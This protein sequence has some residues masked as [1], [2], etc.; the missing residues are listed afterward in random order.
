MNLPRIKGRDACSLLIGILWLLPSLSQAQP[1]DWTFTVAGDMRRYVDYQGIH[2]WDQ[3]CA[4]IAAIGPGAFMASPGDLDQQYTS[5]PGDYVYQIVEQ[6]IAPGYPFF[7]GVGNHEFDDPAS[8]AWIR[9]FDH[10]GP[11]YNVNPGPPGSETTTYSWNHGDAHFVMINECFDGI[12]DIGSIEGN[13]NPALNAWLEADLAANLH[14][15]TFVF[16]HFPAYPQPDRDTGLQLHAT[17][18]DF[19][20]FDGGVYRDALWSLLVSHGVTAYVCGHS[21]TA[22]AVQIDGVWQIDMAHARGPRDQNFH[23]PST[24]LR[25]L[26]G[27]DGSADLETWRQPYTSGAGNEAPYSLWH[28]DT[29][30]AAPPVAVEP[31]LPAVRV[32]QA[33]PNPFN[34]TLNIQL[35][36]P[37]ATFGRVEIID[38]TGRIVSVLHDGPLPAGRSLWTW[39][40]RTDNNLSLPSGSYRIRATTNTTTTTKPITLLR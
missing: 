25:F 40:G 31:A 2:G 9:G 33:W 29:L 7:P 38:L 20:A 30:K 6:E 23:G 36:I 21:H 12:D 19:N 32:I 26:I 4:A 15:L 35:E 8:M 1:G 24:F 28:T 14:P 17:D 16:G 37:D 27:A 18:T 11:A 22:S 39:N 3:A 5:N 34:P 10:G 13:W